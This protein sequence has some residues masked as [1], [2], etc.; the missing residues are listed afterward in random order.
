MFFPMGAPRNY[1][2]KQ[3]GDPLPLVASAGRRIHFEEVDILG[4]VW[5]GNYASF[6]EDGRV[7]FG[8]IY[9]LNY[10]T[11]RENKT[12]APIVQMHLDYKLPL[13]IDDSIRVEAALHWTETARLN[14]SYTIFNPKGQI[15]TKGYTVQMLTDPEGTVMFYTPDW[16]REF[17]RKWREGYWRE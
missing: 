6:F 5:H 4:M 2:K 10:H 3:E 1:F 7:A 17:H 14:F 9:G 13:R 11:M 16:L 15:A 8:D 12:M